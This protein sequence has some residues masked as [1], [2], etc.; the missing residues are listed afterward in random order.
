MEPIVLS[1]PKLYHS[2]PNILQCYDT[3]IAAYITNRGLPYQWLFS[4][5]WGFYYY[6]REH[7]YYREH[8][9]R[10]P[11]WDALRKLYGV[12]KTLFVDIPLRALIEQQVV[13]Q[14]RPLIMIADEYDLHWTPEYRNIH[15]P[16]YFMITEADHARDRV[17]INDWWPMPFQDW[18]ELAALERS[19]D[20]A[21][22]HAFSLTDP[23]FNFTVERLIRQME[24]A[25]QQMIGWEQGGLSAGIF[26]IERFK[27]DM[28]TLG[29]DALPCIDHWFYTVKQTIEARYLFLEY[30]TFL[31]EEHQCPIPPSY[32]QLLERTVQAWFAFRNTMM[33]GKLRGI[34]RPETVG[35]RLDKVIQHES[36]CAE[37]WGQ[38]IEKTR[39]ALS[40]D[41]CRS[42]GKEGE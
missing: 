24:L 35:N 27:R 30:A 15:H 11:L 41:T 2:Y 28:L 7:F 21:G 16:H 9:T 17:F 42:T 4:E 20:E 19:Y 29:T 31:R 32:I 34:W 3:I 12:K 10:Y 33:S 1:P 37:Q 40:S 38:I 6:D 22:R 5:H 13:E 39:Q 14:G 23:S 25:H 18:F 26:G 36:E 8:Y